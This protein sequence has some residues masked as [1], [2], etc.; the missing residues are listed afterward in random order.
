[1][2]LTL[3]RLLFLL[4]TD[5]R[6]L[7]LYAVCRTESISYFSPEAGNTC[8][9]VAVLM[10]CRDLSTSPLGSGAFLVSSRS[11]HVE[12]VRLGKISQAGRSPG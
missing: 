7:T 3:R 9:W 4:L 12:P 5:A 10:S 1:M 6:L 11:S 8:K 2:F